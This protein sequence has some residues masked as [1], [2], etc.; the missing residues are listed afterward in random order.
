MATRRTSPS[1]PAPAS[2]AR[3]GGGSGRTKAGLEA[4]L[5]TV[6]QELRL[7]DRD[8]AR[9]ERSV[10]GAR[11]LLTIAALILL[12]YAFSLSTRRDVLR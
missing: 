1:R 2:G 8:R 5:G 9:M 4:E 11:Y 10:K 12:F 7:V 3:G 6:R